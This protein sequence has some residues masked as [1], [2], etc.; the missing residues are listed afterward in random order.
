MVLPIA[1][2][3]GAVAAAAGISTFVYSKFEEY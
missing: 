1:V 2:A 3:L